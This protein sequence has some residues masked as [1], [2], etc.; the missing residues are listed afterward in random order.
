MQAFVVCRVVCRRERIKLFDL[1]RLSSLHS[2]FAGTWWPENKYLKIS[3]SRCRCL[4]PGR[5]KM[6]SGFSLCL[7]VCTGRSMYVL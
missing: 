3:F 2:T 7:P 5:S 4:L 1:I 6:M